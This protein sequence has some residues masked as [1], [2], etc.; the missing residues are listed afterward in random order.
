M[1]SPTFGPGSV[2]AVDNCA[3]NRSCNIYP[4]ASDEGN[5]PV[6][7]YIVLYRL[8]WTATDVCGNSR[9][10]H[11]FLALIDEIPPVIH[12]VPDD[13]TVNCNEIP[14]PPALVFATDECLCACIITYEQIGPFPGCQDGQVVMRRWT[15]EDDCG[16]VTVEIQNITLIDLEGPEIILQVPEL[17]GLP[18]RT[19]LDY[20]CNE[21][22]IPDIFDD[23]DASVGYQPGFMRFS[24][25]DHI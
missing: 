5:C 8:T 6:D 22:G 21:G 16:N 17:N 1:G 18:D 20:T 12:N 23:L 19:I 2:S 14:E 13:I 7:G 24:W 11:V 3:G 15:A 9:T 4:S 25:N 10:A